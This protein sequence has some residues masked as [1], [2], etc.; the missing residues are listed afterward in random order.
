MALKNGLNIILRRHN[1]SI[2]WISNKVFPVRPN[3]VTH[4]IRIKVQEKVFGPKR[5]IWTRA[6]MSRGEG[7]SK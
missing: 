7:M 4:L 2:A 3:H 5:V 6:K 1:H